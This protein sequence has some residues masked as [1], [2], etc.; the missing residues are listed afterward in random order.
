VMKIRGMQNTAAAIQNRCSR[1]LV[2]NKVRCGIV[3]SGQ[4][5][6]VVVACLDMMFYCS[7]C[8]SRLMSSSVNA[9]LTQASLRRRR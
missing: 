8:G 2:A 5:Q 9:F 6:A 7:V 4:R 1:L 3:K